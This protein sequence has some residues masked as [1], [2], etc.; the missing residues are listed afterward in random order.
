M[1]HL[2][3]CLWPL[4]LWFMLSFKCFSFAPTLSVEGSSSLSNA[5]TA[6]L[7][8]AWRAAL[9]K[10]FHVWDVS[11]LLYIQSCGSV[12]P[13][14]IIKNSIFLPKLSVHAMGIGYCSYSVFLSLLLKDMN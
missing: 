8:A 14:I 12:L 9:Y 7:Q 5:N 6:T 10:A 11:F 1:L 2:W 3:L 4:L 13:V